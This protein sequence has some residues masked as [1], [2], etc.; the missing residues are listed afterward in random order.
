MIVGAIVL[1]LV[2]LAA[3]AFFSGSETG[4]Y[5]VSQL[6]L[7]VESAEGRWLSR[8]LLWSANRPSQFVAT[9]LIGNNIAN[10][11]ISLAVLLFFRAAGGGAWLESVA[12]VALTPVL[13][14]YGELLPKR[15]FEQAPNRL[16]A[17]TGPAFLL[18]MVLFYPLSWALGVLSTLL[19]YLLGESP[20]RVQ[21]RLIRN[22]ILRVMEEGHVAG[23]LRPIQRDLAEN[24]LRAGPERIATRMTP[25]GRVPI[26]RVGMA[27][28]DVIRLARPAGWRFLP[29]SDGRAVPIGT[30]RVIDLRLKGRTQVAA[31][32]LLPLPIYRDDRSV[33][34]VAA[35]MQIGEHELARIVGPRGA[36]VG[37]QR[38]DLLIANLLGTE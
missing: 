16:L 6:R 3:S 1:F 17:I 35:A 22:E 37:Y 34:D 25:A 33:L 13:F 36:T 30:L 23:L 9:A 5:R 8:G 21:F 24:L 29:V 32:D 4:F 14:I 11:L 7:V 31:E 15:L 19:Q 10:Y 12:P 38:L 2:A 26:V 28:E 20:E 27:T 18:C